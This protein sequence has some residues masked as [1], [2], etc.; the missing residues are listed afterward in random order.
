[1]S[2]KLTSTDIISSLIRADQTEDGKF[3]IAIKFT[4]NDDMDRLYEDLFSGAI[5]EVLLDSII[6]VR[7]FRAKHSSDEIKKIY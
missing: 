1:M 6:T 5:E 2:K 3:D 7:N 4:E